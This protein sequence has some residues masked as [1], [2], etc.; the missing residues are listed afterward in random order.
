MPIATLNPA[1]GETLRT[2]D[3]LTAGEI[4]A[5]L[6]KAVRAFTT[7]RLTPFEERAA[8]LRR[9]GEILM[10][11]KEQLGRLM[12][13]EMGKPITAAIAEAEK[14]ATACFYY[15]ENGAQLL[16]DYH[17]PTAGGEGRVHFQPLGA[18]LAIMPWNFPFWQVFRFAA[19]ALMAGNVGLLKHSS[20]VPQ[21]A[22]AIEDILRRSGFTDGAFQTLLIGSKDVASI[23][24]DHRI[25]A[26]T[27]TG[28]ESAGRSV[29]ETAGRALK[30]TVL[31]LGGSDPFIVMPSAD[32]DS[33]AATAVKARMIN[34]G[35]SCIA[36]KRFIVHDAIYDR[37]LDRFLA[38]VK[39]VKIGDPM[40]ASTEL[41]PLAISD[42]RDDLATQVEKSI[43]L[44]ARALCGGR[45]IDQPGFYYEPTVLVDIP[46]ASPA[47]DEEL[48]G[49][50]ASVWRVSDIDEAIA[51]ANR[52]RFGL[53]S[54]VWTTDAVE[55]EHFIRDIEAG[56][57]FINGMVASEA[58]LP[59]GGVKSSGYGRELGEF[60]IRE[61]VNIKSVKS[62]SGL[63]ARADTE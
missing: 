12:T 10:A 26:V 46:H 55:R 61:F 13:L 43:S 8:S 40:D 14:C 19:P 63:A 39:A 11:E 35:Q 4:D 51:T 9:A 15:A 1:T 21:C 59:F 58:G 32:V 50:V 57:V 37:F 27:I 18:V 49:P 53:G 5:C 3:P 22:L 29:A 62:A 42:I 20:N 45:R 48:F 60:G 33:A 54:S 25:A 52:S 41:G 44:G 24:E 23:I 2:F 16:A 34:N 28:S 6:A 31:E 56:M 47:D 30:K 36:A 7:H 38:G 17:V